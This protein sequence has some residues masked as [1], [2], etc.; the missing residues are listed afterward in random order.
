MGSV[1]TL[2]ELAVDLPLRDFAGQIAGAL[3]RVSMR[4][5]AA[6]LHT[7][8]LFPGGSTVGVEIAP[9]HGSYLV[10]DMGSATR[11][12]ELL[13]V[14]RIF[15]KIAQ[16][17]ARKYGVRFDHHM[18]FDIE[19]PA[20]EVVAA[21]IAV[22]NAA[23]SAV[24]TAAQAAATKDRLDLKTVFWHRLETVFRGVQVQ[25]NFIARGSSDQWSFDAAIERHGHLTLFELVSP[26][27]NSVSAAVT[28]FLDVSDLGAAAP[29]RVGVLTAKD[30]TPHLPVLARTAKVISKDASD[31]AYL[32][33]A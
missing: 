8:L 24:E 5:Q 17:A 14:E 7:P 26:H 29:H 4:D 25:R 12:A 19:V 22:A 9:L 16:E 10:T 27:A 18:L 11:E 1:A 28:K 3:V 6:R 32:A 31:E 15:S 13:G 2:I 30:R 23:K 20:D 21:V 33:A